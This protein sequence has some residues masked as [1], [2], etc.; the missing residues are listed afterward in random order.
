MGDVLARRI[1]KSLNLERGWMDTPPTYTELHDGHSYTNQVMLC[2]ESMSTE[3]QATV[4][5]LVNAVAKPKE[6]KEKNGTT[7]E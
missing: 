1:E 7:G 6:S 5:R 2:M 3:D 4:F